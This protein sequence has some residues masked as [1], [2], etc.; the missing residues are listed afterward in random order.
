LWAI[1]T[2]GGLFL[3]EARSPDGSRQIIGA[4]SHRAVAR[5]V[6]K[7]SHEDIEWSALEK[8]AEVNIQDVEDLLPF[9]QSVVERVN[10]KLS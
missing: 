3:V 5:H 8:S 6:A 4:G 10:Q 1:S 9:W 2:V 7:R